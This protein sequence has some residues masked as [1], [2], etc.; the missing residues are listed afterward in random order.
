MADNFI[1]L[2]NFLY[3]ILY[4]YGV[5][6][7]NDDNNGLISEIVIP[8]N[9]RKTKFFVWYIEQSVRFVD[10]LY[11]HPYALYIQIQYNIY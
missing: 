8:F 11:V 3:D 5:E 7:L 2:C 6:L 9:K 4:E 1:E 10:N